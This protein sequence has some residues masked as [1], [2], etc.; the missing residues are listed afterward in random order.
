MADLSFLDGTAL[1]LP[2]TGLPV[3]VLWTRGRGCRAL[4]ELL[5]SHEPVRVVSD[6]VDTAVQ[7]HSTVLVSRRLPHSTLLNVVVP[8]DFVPGKVRSVVAAVAGGP[9]SRAAALVARRLGERLQ[10][11]SFM[12]CAFRGDE[13]REGAVSVVES[14]FPHV[15]DLEYRLMG[16]DSAGHLISQLP[17]QCLLVIGAPGGNW[18]QRVLF[19]R[20]AR[21]RQRAAG[22]VVIVRSAPLRVFQIMDAPR[23]VS[24]YHHAADVLRL[25]S[26]ELLA[27]AENGGLVGLVRR[28]SLLVAGEESPVAHAME[29]A[30]SIGMVDALSD[31]QSQI[32]WFGDSPIPVIDPQGRL[33]GSVA[34]CSDQTCR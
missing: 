14:L 11:P 4:A 16:A 29:K 1:S 3:P 31:L 10:V 13:S 9:H 32:E 7:W 19:G 17:P 20:G 2:R 6:L 22:G 15:P 8:V 30:R 21:L 27:V 33:V 34:G 25:H 28:S 18:F 26:N 5:G 23:F 24:P 12:A